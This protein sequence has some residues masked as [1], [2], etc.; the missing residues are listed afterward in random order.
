MSV[1]HF[2]YFLQLKI[3]WA[4]KLKSKFIFSPQ[5][6]IYLAIRFQVPLAKFSWRNDTWK[7]RKLSSL[8]AGV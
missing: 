6:S 4:I 2:Y 1:V 5:M 3:S 7:C 8:W